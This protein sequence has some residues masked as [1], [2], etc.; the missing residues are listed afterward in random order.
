MSPDFPR[1]PQTDQQSASFLSA[2]SQDDLQGFLLWHFVFIQE[3]NNLYPE[4]F[5]QNFG[6]WDCDLRGSV[7]ICV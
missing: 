2:P 7:Y 1:C 5:C 4:Q 6:K 3:N